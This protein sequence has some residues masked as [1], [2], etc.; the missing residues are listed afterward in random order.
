MKEIDLKVISNKYIGFKVVDIIYDYDCDI[1][2]KRKA[3]CL[4]DCG[5]EFVCRVDALKDKRGCKKCG[6]KHGGK[7]RLLP[8]FEGA[9]HNYFKS[10]VHNAVVRK[11][12][13]NLSYEEFNSIII[14]DCH[15]C[16]M[17]PQNQ[18]YLCKS[19]EKYGKFFAS[20]VDRVY[21]EKGYSLDNVVPCCT[22][23]N[24][25]KKTLPYE[26]FLEHV[27]DIYEHMKHGFNN[28]I[29]KYEN[30]ENVNAD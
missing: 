24:M 29:L 4:C 16:G 30:E 11:I 20:G 17:S 25:M 9:K 1:H 10:Y 28:T 8:N 13:F 15:Y 27:C 26:M 12:Q 3:E 5:E 21:N 18:S 2:R 14:Q 22:K 23:C 19:K 7:S 6:C